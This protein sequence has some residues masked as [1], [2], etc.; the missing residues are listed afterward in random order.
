MR[1]DSLKDANIIRASIIERHKRT[2]EPFWVIAHEYNMDEELV[3]SFIK[4][5]KREETP[6]RGQRWI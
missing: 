6:I 4:Y 1:P 5:G 2:G 3:N